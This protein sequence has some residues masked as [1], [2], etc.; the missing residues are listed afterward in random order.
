VSNTSDENQCDQIGQ[1]YAILAGFFSI[2]HFLK[3]PPRK[4]IVGRRLGH[5]CG[6]WAIFSQKHL[7]TPTLVEH[8]R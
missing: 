6:H 1:N 2:G 8:F 7:V 5:F 4:K 3:F